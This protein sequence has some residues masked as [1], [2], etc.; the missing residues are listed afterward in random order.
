MW[1]YCL[2]PSRESQYSQFELLN[3]VGALNVVGWLYVDNV[4]DVIKLQLVINWKNH[5]NET[6]ISEKI[7]LG[8]RK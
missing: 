4:L 2:L 3:H 1:C 5:E 7:F 6:N 8:T